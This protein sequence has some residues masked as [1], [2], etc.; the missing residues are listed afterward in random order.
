MLSVVTEEVRR[1]IGCHLSI[2]TLTADHPL[3]QVAGRTSHSDEYARW[4]NYEFKVDE[5]G[6]NAEV[7][8]SNRPMRLTQAELEGH[9]AWAGSGQ[10]ADDHP[11]MRG[12]LAAPLVGREGRNIGLIQ[13]SDK[14]EGEFNEEDESV[15][16]Q[17]A[18]TGSV[19]VEKA[20]LHDQLREA[21]R[22][23]DE[24]LATL[25]HELRN[26][27]APIRNGL[28]VM[29]LAARPGGRMSRPAP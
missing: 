17:L 20:R 1:L 26:P 19:A 10:R 5:A 7:I 24:F 4:K 2:T 6:I 14:Y 29:R 16:V 9:S 23:K 27:L 15:L 25:A 12:Y 22:R 11:F 13:L 8:R 21:D 18:E 3:G 28:Q